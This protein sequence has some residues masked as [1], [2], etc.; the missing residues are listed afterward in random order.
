MYRLCF[1]SVQAV[2]CVLALPAT[3]LAG[4]GYVLS[5]SFLPS[6]NM[7]T[8]YWSS[9]ERGSAAM[10]CPHLLLHSTDD[11]LVPAKHV[12]EFGRRL[13]AEARVQVTRKEWAKSG[14]VAHLRFHREEYVGALREFLPPPPPSE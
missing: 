1:V 3:V 9:L 8:A 6:R 2:F 5:L 11:A 13:E 14:H 7:T 4:L 10:A 12:R